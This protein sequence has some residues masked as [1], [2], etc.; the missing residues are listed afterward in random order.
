MCSRFVGSAVWRAPKGEWGPLSRY[1]IVALCI[2]VLG[3]IVFFAHWPWLYH[4]TQARVGEYVEFHRQHEHYPVDYF[5]HLYMLPPFPMNYPWVMTLFTVPLATLVLGGV[6]LVICTQRIWQGIK[7][8][9]GRGHRGV[10]ECLLVLNLMVPIVIISLPNTPIFGGT[11]HW[12][13][14]MPFLALTAG[15]GAVRVMDGLFG[16]IAGRKE[17]DIRLG[18]R[19]GDAPTGRVGDRYVWSPWAGLF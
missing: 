3:S 1:G 18:T 4:D 9:D 10:A 17:R 13:P 12:M 5:G 8:D 11:K 16:S 15:I 6:G 2:I 7:S 14:A 19:D